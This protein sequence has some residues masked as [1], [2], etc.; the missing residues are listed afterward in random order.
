MNQVKIGQTLKDLRKQNNL[1]Q[2]ALANKFNVS[3][4]SVSRWETGNNLP[5][6]SLLIELA[7]FYNVDIRN[8]LDGKIVNK[9][10][11]DNET[12]S[13]IADYNIKQTKDKNKRINILI[14]TFL[15]LF[16]VISLLHLYCLNRWFE[17]DITTCVYINMGQFALCIIGFIV[18]ICAF[19]DEYYKNR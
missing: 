4:R 14:I 18:S 8:L 12:L 6:I 3:N 19:I 15:I 2:E 5:D 10:N 17:D 9:D 16:I 11:N 7:D 13:L 1:T